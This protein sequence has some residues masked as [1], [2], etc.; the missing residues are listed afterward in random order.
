MCGAL[1]TNLQLVSGGFYLCCFIEDTNSII[2]YVKL[3]CD[4]EWLI[5]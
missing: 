4:C 3:V 2:V 1:N 5:H